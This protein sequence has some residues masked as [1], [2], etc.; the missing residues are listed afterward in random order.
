MQQSL[1]AYDLGDFWIVKSSNVHVQGRYCSDNGASKSLCAIA[2]GGSL[3][4]YQTLVIEPLGHWGL[5][6]D[7]QWRGQP[8]KNSATFE[9]AKQDG[10]FWATSGYGAATNIFT[11]ANGL[12][13]KVVR[14][15]NY[16]DTEIT[17]EQQGKQSGH[18]GNFNLDAGDDVGE[19]QKN[20]NLVPANQVLFT[21][22]ARSGGK[23]GALTNIRSC[24]AA[25]KSKAAKFCADNIPCA[26]PSELQACVFD[27][28]FADAGTQ[29]E[30]VQFLAKMHSEDGCPTIPPETVAPARKICTG[31][32]SNWN[33]LTKEGCQK[34]VDGYKFWPCNAAKLVS[35]C[36]C[37]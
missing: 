13:L 24:D 37:S 9:K 29:E 23:R 26:I 2:V 36:Q 8:I 11:F 21:K 28:C 22:S 35:L 33:G 34:C 30:D 3:L 14:Q 10:L 31:V 4:N 19:L 17:M 16:L 1:D 15:S 27:A 6:F 20:R 7:M 5:T 25:V 12:I 32:K 18:C